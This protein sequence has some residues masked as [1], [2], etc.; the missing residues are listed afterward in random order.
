[1]FESI[2]S[3][4]ESV[5]SGERTAE[6]I[7]KETLARVDAREPSVKAFLHVDRD[8]FMTAA[9]D[10]DAKRARGE[11]LGLLAGV[12]IAIKDALCMT[13]V[14][15]TAGSRILEG[16]KPVYDAT[17]VKKLRE[18]D[19][20]LVGKTNLDEFAMGSSNENSAYAK[21]H[22][23]WDLTRA[24]GGSSGG[25]AA[26][27]AS[28]MCP[29]SLGSDTGGSIRQ[30][31]SFCGIVGVK[32]TYGRVSRYGLIAFASSL[33]QVGPFATDVRGAARMLRVLSGQDPHD[34]TTLDAPVDDFEAACNTPI[35]GLRVGIPREY[36]GEGLD[37]EV[38]M[39][40]RRAISCL[41]QF[42][43][44][45]KPV[46]LPHTKYAVAAYYVLATAEASSNLARFDGV[47]YGLRKEPG[48]D[49]R[50]MYGATRDAGFGPEVKRRI[51][52]GTF[53]LSSGFYDAYYLKAQKVRTLI[54]RDFDAAFNEV[55]VL[56]APTA[57]TT[58]F[59]LGEKTHDP[60]AMYL[61]DIDTLPASLAGVPAMSIPV[62]LSADGMPIGLQIITPHLQEARG[63]AIAAACER[64]DALHVG[65][66]TAFS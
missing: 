49:L 61:S 4:A 20:T 35:K 15:T 60:L 42:G 45:V 9:R 63:F 32:P 12:P 30:P 17:V 23:P 29:G 21:V 51:L 8:G 64:H 62:G 41:E 57:P 59:R 37:P 46:S 24:P 14:P 10:V 3:L 28:R 22:N 58:A 25:S 1:M 18:A 16:Y 52:L 33:D 13:G 36:F 27:V 48:R 31:A 2:V 66:P 34:A 65:A 53:V 47:R 19:A 7:A 43:C 54:T 39:A 56:C 38:N 26:A 11:D 44:T 6:S 5:R 55:D 50:A 40:V